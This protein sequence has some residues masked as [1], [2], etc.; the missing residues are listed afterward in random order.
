MEKNTNF[1]YDLMV[2]GLGPA[3]MAASLMASALGLRV[4]AIEK[5]WL[6]GECMNVGCIPSKSLLRMAKTRTL[7]DNPAAWELE[8]AGKAAVREPLRRV[9][10]YVSQI[11]EQKTAKLFQNIAVVLRNGPGYF[12]DPHTLAVGNRRLSGRKIIIASGSTA[13]IPDVPGIKDVP[14]LTNETVFSLTQ[15]PAS[16]II[17]GGGAVGCELAQAFTRL[18]TKCSI[19]N[20]DQQLLPHADPEASALLQ[21]MFLK[22]GIAVYNDNHLSKV[23]PQA[24]AIAVQTYKGTALSAE[25]LL[26]AA[27]RTSNTAELQLKNAGVSFTDDGITVNRFLQTSQPHIYAVGDCTGMKRF[28]HAAMHQA[29]LAIMNCL[30]PWPMPKKSPQRYVVPWSVFTE[31]EISSVGLTEKEI[32]QRDLE[33]TT[34][35]AR[36]EDYGAAISQNTGKG[37]V[38]V[39]SGRK[40]RILGVTI[41]GENS[42]EMINEWAL[43]MQHR[44]TLADIMLTQHSFPTMGFLTQRVAEQWMTAE[45]QSPRRQK[46]AQ[47]LFRW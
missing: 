13:F 46:I 10:D 23:M 19:V 5:Q 27:G 38:K 32:Q 6:G 37:F 3:G 43:S 39:F 8:S 42:G 40:G 11:R 9:Q 36:Y 41:A 15:L 17:I 1:D 33:Y 7:F 25:M 44:L 29:K 47:F 12:I 31:P 34:H 28:T 21:K 26:V 22:E 30:S 35:V 24:D 45:M 4:C 16:L 2:I 14:Y 20:M 18:G